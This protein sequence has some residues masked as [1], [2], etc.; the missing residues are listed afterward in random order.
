MRLQLMIL[1]SL[2]IQE[3]GEAGRVLSEIQDQSV[4]E[5]Y[6]LDLSH[7][8]A[9]CCTKLSNE[10]IVVHHYTLEFNHHKVRSPSTSLSNSARVGT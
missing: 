6:D 8:V 9:E 4:I 3:T 7:V 10:A 2:G 1:V 5:R